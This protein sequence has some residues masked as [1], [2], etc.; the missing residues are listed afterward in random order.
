VCVR[1]G[2]RK[3]VNSSG[4]SEAKKAKARERYFGKSRRKGKAITLRYV[5]L[6]IP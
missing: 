2:K 6:L 1:V 3:V 5:P 4:I